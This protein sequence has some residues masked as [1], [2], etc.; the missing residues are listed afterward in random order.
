MINGLMAR[1]RSLWRGIGR[2][3]AV[4]GEMNEEFRLHIELRAKDLENTGVS[5]HVALALARREFG[6]AEYHRDDARRSRGPHRVDGIRFSWLDFRLGARMMMKYPG[7]TLISGIGMPVGI[8]IASGW[9]SVMRVLMQ[10]S[11]PLPDGDRIVALQN[12]ETK[13]D[14]RGQ[15]RVHDFI[16]WRDNLQSVRDI[17][18]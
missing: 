10:S 17:G 1:L 12:W 6:A 3:D 5:A 18:A 9:G 8:A 16:S 7:L 11:R 2:R 13:S 14:R 15:A 4:E